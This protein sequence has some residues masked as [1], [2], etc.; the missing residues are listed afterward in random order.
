MPP[1]S[2]V[3]AGLPPHAAG[4][5]IGL[6]GGS[7]NPAHQGHRQVSLLALRRLQLDWLWWLVTP[8]NPLKDVAALPS[9]AARLQAAARIAAHPRI[10]LTSVEAGFRTRYTADFIRRLKLCAPETRFVWIM[11]GDNL[12]QLHRWDRWREIA[13][14]VPI[15]VI[16]RPG[17][18]NAALAAQAAQALAKW[19]VDERSAPVLAGFAPPAWTYLIG[20]RTAASSTALRAARQRPS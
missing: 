15:A 5:R 2:R 6:Y 1:A 8:G 20:P 9:L 10:V 13:V 11:G 18:L 12:A 3:F 14:S 17:H 16:N 19:R 7:F 4:Q